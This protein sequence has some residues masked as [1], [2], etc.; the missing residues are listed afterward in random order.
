ML[1][2]LVDVTTQSEHILEVRGPVI[3]L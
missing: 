2:G 1:V 3:S